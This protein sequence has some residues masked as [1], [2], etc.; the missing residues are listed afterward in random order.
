M[1]ARSGEITWLSRAAEGMFGSMQMSMLEQGVGTRE[2][3]EVFRD[4]GSFYLF[5]SLLHKLGRV[6]RIL[7]GRG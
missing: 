4:K 5:S 1:L 2:G 7:T 6:L 3:E